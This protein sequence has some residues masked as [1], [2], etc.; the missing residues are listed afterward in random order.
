MTTKINI[1]IVGPGALGCL[2]AARLQLAGYAPVLID[3]KK[4]RASL[5][6]EQG[7]TL[8]C[9]GQTTQL[10][11]KTEFHGNC[12]EN[13]DII[14]FCVKSYSLDK[15]I[16]LCKSLIKNSQLALFM[17]NGISH[18]NPELE[19]AAA[20]FGSTTEGANLIE[21]GHVVQAGQ[22]NTSLGFLS[23]ASE[24]KMQLLE[25][26]CNSLKNSGIKTEISASIKQVIWQKLLINIGINGLTAIY[27]CTNGS[28]LE[29]A[30]IK[31]RMIKAVEEAEK[32]AAE[33]N[34]NFLKNP[35]N[36]VVQVC[37]NTAE[38]ISSMLQDVRGGRK[39][40]IDAIN[41][42]LLKLAMKKNLSCPENKRIVE[43][44]KAIE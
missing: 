16:S 36:Q 17:Q 13:F 12:S 37:K 35:Q 19:G 29:N 20:C 22:G 26:F 32:V 39:T 38:N 42:A 18:L 21:T 15:S 14:V 2:L 33:Y 23:Q 25:L 27:N 40:E 44:V 31:A 24:K 41:G 1:G 9:H 10:P 3:Y 5:L 8:S 30:E 34:V 6:N 11:V 28:L 43:Q 4:D 7:I